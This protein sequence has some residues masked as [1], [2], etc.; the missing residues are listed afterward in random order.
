MSQAISKTL[1]SLFLWQFISVVV[2][3]LTQVLLARTLGPHDKG[4]L[5]LFL[6]IPIVGGSIADLGLLTSNTYFAGKGTYSLPSLHTNSVLW[7]LGAG[8]ALVLIALAVSAG[9]GSPFPTLGSDMVLLAVAAIAPSI[10]SSLWSGLMYG[11]DHAGKVY[12]VAAI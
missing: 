11:S 9:G 2:G 5:D 3:L 6:L 8:L 10:Y 4:I 12:A 7:S 1:P